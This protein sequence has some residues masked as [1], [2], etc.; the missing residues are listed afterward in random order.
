MARTES[1]RR[2]EAYEGVLSGRELHYEVTL[3]FRQKIEKL[4]YGARERTQDKRNRR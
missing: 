2:H 3:P 4:P 1:P